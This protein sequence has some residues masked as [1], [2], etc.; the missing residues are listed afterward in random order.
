MQKSD[1]KNIQN[2]SLFW[3]FDAILDRTKT[4]QKKIQN[5]SMKYVLDDESLIAKEKT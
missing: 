2:W 1:C 5:F 3:I 4:F